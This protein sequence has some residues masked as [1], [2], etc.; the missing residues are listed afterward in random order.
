MINLI[1]TTTYKAFGFDVN[2]M[3][4]L[5]ELQKVSDCDEASDINIMIT[6]LTE[7]LDKHGVKGQYFTVTNEFVLFHVPEIAIFLIQDGNTI[8]VSPYEGATTD[9]IRLYLLG[10][11]MGILLMQRKILPLHGSALAIDGKAYAIVGDSGAGKS[12]LASA[13]LK[14][15]YGLISDD[16]IPVTLSEE[17][18]PMVT[19]AYPQQKLWQESLTEFGMDSVGYRPIVDRE[20]KFAIPVQSQFVTESMPLAGVFELVK[21]NDDDVKLQP[22]TGLERFQKLYYHTYR[23]FL[24]EPMGL[25][26]W[27]FNLCAQMVSKLRVYQLQRPV[28]RFTA[29]DLVSLLLSTVQEGENK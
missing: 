26:Q 14:Q 23:N 7:K 5:P 17:G 22:I 21:T 16:V 2:S 13:L 25:M 19:P 3:I 20:T 4:D 8:L 24:L 6:D 15:G 1:D 9:H 12:T 11:C 10:T 27:H 29:N 18:I 28:S